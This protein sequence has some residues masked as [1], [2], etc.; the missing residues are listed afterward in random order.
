MH[1]LQF[2]LIYVNFALQQMPPAETQGRMPRVE[3]PALL[4]AHLYATQPGAQARQREFEMFDIGF[5]AAF[6][7]PALNSAGQ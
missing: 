4:V 3:S 2:H 5:E 6:V 1:P 7:Q